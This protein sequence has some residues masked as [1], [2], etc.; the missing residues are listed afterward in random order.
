MS[1]RLD[2]DPLTLR[3]ARTL[4]ETRRCGHDWWE[5]PMHVEPRRR[6]PWFARLLR[7]LMGR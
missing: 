6:R 2:R 4:R 1:A 5:G 7:R 3:V